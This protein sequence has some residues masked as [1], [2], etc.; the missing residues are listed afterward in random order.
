M[1]LILLFLGGQ[2]SLGAFSQDK[3]F[4]SSTALKPLIANSMAKI[5]QLRA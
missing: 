4:I 3:N 1:L 5:P 2:S